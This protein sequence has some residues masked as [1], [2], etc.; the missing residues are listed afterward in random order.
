MVP[1]LLTMLELSQVIGALAA[2]RVD[3]WQTSWCY[4]FHS[5]KCS[6]LDV[7][8]RKIQM[9]QSSPTITV[10]TK[11]AHKHL[12]IPKNSGCGVAPAICSMG[13]SR[14]QPCSFA[15]SAPFS[16]FSKACCI[17]VP[18]D[19]LHFNSV[20]LCFRWGMVLGIAG[21][22]KVPLILKIGKRICKMYARDAYSLSSI[23]YDYL[24][25]CYLVY[26]YIKKRHRK[27]KMQQTSQC[28]MMFEPVDSSHHHS[29]PRF[30]DWSL[31]HMHELRPRAHTSAKGPPTNGR[32]WPVR[33]DLASN[34][35]HVMPD[36]ECHPFPSVR[37]N[38][39]KIFLETNWTLP[40][41]H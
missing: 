40:P 9:K 38:L 34:K 31:N 6:S 21:H 12:R 20:S 2:C 10:C 22:I 41:L 13:Q 4:K 23:K 39:P 29:N 17:E 26:N 14:L 11:V 27:T 30:F 28:V 33:K 18:D 7:L 35:R 19:F 3:N 32:P 1:S 5:S 16:Q 8:F 25:I 37:I 24:S 36:F 15:V